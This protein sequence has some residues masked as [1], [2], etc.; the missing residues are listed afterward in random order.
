MRKYEGLP[1]YKSDQVQRIFADLS[2]TVRSLTRRRRHPECQLGLDT[3]CSFLFKKSAPKI[4]NQQLERLAVIGTKV[5]EQQQHLAAISARRNQHLEDL[6]APAAILLSKINQ[7]RANLAA[8][9]TK[10][11]WQITEPRQELPQAIQQNV[12]LL[13]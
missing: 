10:T 13:L 1:V 11:E 4:V 2:R 6:A 12:L 5:E 3:L 7:Q 8:L 9:N